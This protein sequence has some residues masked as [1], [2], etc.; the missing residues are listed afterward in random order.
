MTVGT[1]SIGVYLM[2]ALVRDD[3]QR[4][5]LVHI[6]KALTILADLIH[7]K[8]ASLGAPWRQRHILGRTHDQ[9]QDSRLFD[10][11]YHGDTERSL[12]LVEVDGEQAL[13][14]LWSFRTI[15]GVRRGLEEGVDDTD[16]GCP[17]ARRGLG[18]AEILCGEFE[19]GYVGLG[20]RGL[21]RRFSWSTKEDARRTF[22][23]NMRLVAA[24]PYV[25]LSDSIT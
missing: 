9:A 5:H 16:D 21:L 1:S 13:W 14:S 20:S 4:T 7:T 23:P 25:L 6:L 12:V 8:E 24:G 2:S 15:F 19:E 22:S 10:K 17:A 18:S 3:S 11:R